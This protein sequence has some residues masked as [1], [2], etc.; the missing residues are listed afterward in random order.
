MRDENRNG[1]PDAVEELAADASKSLREL[2]REARKRAD[3]AKSQAVKGLHE[4]AERLR[5]EAHER[6]AEGEALEKVNETASGLE[7]AAAYLKRHSYE[8]IGSDV[9]KKVKQNPLPL[10]ALI[11]FIGVIAGLMLRGGGDRK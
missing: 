3:E 1:V 10:I 7:R 8:Q 2:G 11:F 5:R 4:A 6:G 9:E